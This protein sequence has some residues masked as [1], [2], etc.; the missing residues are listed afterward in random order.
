MIKAFWIS[1]RLRNTYKANGFIYFLRQLPLIKRQLPVGTYKSRAIKGFANVVAVILELINM[2][3]WKGIYL[4]LLF[5]AA[6]SMDPELPGN[7]FFN[8]F[9]FL[10]IAGG[11]LNTQLFDPSNDKY[12]AIVLM[13]MDAKKYT[14]SNYVYFLIRVILG[15]TPFTC[16]FCALLGESFLWGFLLTA[17]VLLIKVVFSGY[18]LWDD[19]RNEKKGQLSDSQEK[20][21]AAYIWLAG[22]ALAALGFGL[23]Y[24]PFWVPAY[25]FLWIVPVLVI[26]AV[27]CAIY[28]FRSRAYGR[29]YKELLKKA[30]AHTAKATNQNQITQNQTLKKIEY[31]AGD[32]VS[33]KKGYAYFNELFMKRHRKLLHKPAKRICVISLIIFAALVVICRLN[34][35]MNEGINEMMLTMLPF[36]LFIMYLIH[37]GRSATQAMF[38][39]CDHSMLSFRFYRQPRVVLSL[40]VER[41]K[42]L[43]LISLVPAAFI[44]AELAGLLWV[45]GGTDTP[46]N[47]VLIFLTIIMMAIFFSVHYMVLYYLL[48]PYNVQLESRNAAYGIA[49][50]L[51]YL[52]CYMAIQRTAPTLI[53]GSAMTVFCI[54]YII[55]ALLLV[56]KKA[57]KTFKLR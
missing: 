36:F 21:M 6:V 35:Q 27:L 1:F 26:P 5:A 47:Y 20:K 53:F 28:L 48:Q 56:Y 38:M 7:I 30:P 54:I 46:A 10:T 39:N 4:L 40:F 11:F 57:P 37:P 23:P 31:T 55:V 22:A 2:F 24:S 25:A 32:V 17:Y 33:H 9:F 42:S 18:I 8:A 50:G 12:Y 51:T 19:V 43:I 49:N 15:F 41:L 16:L 14:L 29:L 3:L 44:G 13:R 52:V 45:T 34:T